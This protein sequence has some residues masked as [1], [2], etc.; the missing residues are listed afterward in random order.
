MLNLVTLVL[1]FVVVN[2]PYTSTTGWFPPR[3]NVV[4]AFLLDT[5]NCHDS[6]RWGWWKED[7]VSK[8][9]TV[10]SLLEGIIDLFVGEGILFVW[11]AWWGCCCA[12]PG[13]KLF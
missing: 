7:K 10:G 6:D 8:K 9:S 11:G 3:S 2:Q 12:L 1:L 13:S 5:T 4:S